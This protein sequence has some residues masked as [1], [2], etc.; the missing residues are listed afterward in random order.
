MKPV[1]NEQLRAIHAALHGKGLL[2]NKREMVSSFTNGRSDSSKD[3]THDEAAELLRSLND[4]KPKEDP[5][6][7]MIRS[8]IAMAREMGVVSRESRVGTNGVIEWKSNYDKLNEW[9]LTKSTC[10]KPLREYTYAELP[11]L[12]TQYRAIYMSW[13]K[14]K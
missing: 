12:V 9:M 13:L 3:L 11:K 5:R 1:T 14:K 4:Y 2:E 10:K 8:I 7:K 6:D